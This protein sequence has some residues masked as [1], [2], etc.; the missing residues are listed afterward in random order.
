MSLTDRILRSAFCRIVRF[1]DS[2]HNE[3]VAGEEWF[4]FSGVCAA[5]LG[6]TAPSIT[7]TLNFRE[8]GSVGLI[9]RGCF[10]AADGI[11]PMGQVERG[12]SSLDYSVT[13]GIIGA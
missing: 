3:F 9:G 10:L 1:H 8:D 4:E 12:R 11:R 2:R 13:G 7:G 5:D 6:E